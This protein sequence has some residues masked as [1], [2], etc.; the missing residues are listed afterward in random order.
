[1]QRSEAWFCG[2][3]DATLQSVFFTHFVS[4]VKAPDFAEIGLRFLLEAMICEILSQSIENVTAER[5]VDESSNIGNSRCRL[6][7]N[8]VDACVVDLG[9]VR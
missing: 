6:S 8:R 5:K 7:G 9:R 3:R 4:C 2:T 1:M